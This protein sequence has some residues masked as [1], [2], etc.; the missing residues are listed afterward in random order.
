VMNRD[1]ID[2]LLA[3]E[4]KLGADA[5]VAAGPVG[6]TAHAATDLK[7]TAKILAYSRAKGLFAGVSVEGSS[8]RDDK[9]AN[10]AVY[11]REYSASD[12]FA[13]AAPAALPPVIRTWRETLRS[14]TPATR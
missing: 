3:S 5:S 12:V 9:D 4:F 6:R 8:L 7:M 13:M 11:G 1:G 14:V 2:D 10:K